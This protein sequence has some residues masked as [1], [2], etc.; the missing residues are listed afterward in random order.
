MKAGNKTSNSCGTH[1]IKSVAYAKEESAVWL[2]AKKDLGAPLA[3]FKK[4]TT[5]EYP[6]LQYNLF[7]PHKVLSA[8]E[9]F[10]KTLKKFTS[11]KKEQDFFNCI[12]LEAY[13]YYF[14]PTQGCCSNS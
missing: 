2:W 5:K 10:P 8:M 4:A 6:L 1:S 12:H 9:V 11:L 13:Y 3:H 14:A 7:S